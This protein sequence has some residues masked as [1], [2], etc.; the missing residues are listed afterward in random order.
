MIWCRHAISGIIILN[1][2]LKYKVGIL[3]KDVASCAIFIVDQQTPVSIV[4]SSPKNT[5]L[6]DDSTIILL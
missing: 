6:I 1:I 3:T 2:R 4:L 5:D